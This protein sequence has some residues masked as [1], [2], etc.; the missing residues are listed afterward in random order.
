VSAET[1]F[2]SVSIEEMTDKQAKQLA[3]IGSNAE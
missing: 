3:L 2:A 1:S